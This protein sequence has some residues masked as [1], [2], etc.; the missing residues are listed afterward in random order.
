VINSRNASTTKSFFPACWMII[1]EILR[2]EC[3]LN[4]IPVPLLPSYLL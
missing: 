4:G 2:D 3:M 1:E